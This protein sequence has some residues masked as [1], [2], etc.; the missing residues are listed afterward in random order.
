MSLFSSTGVRLNHR[1]RSPGPPRPR[2]I[3]HRGQRGRHFAAQGGAI[4]EPG[5]DLQATEPQKLEGADLQTPQIRSKGAF[6]QH[7]DAVRG[8]LAEPGRCAA[9]KVGADRDLGGGTGSMVQADQI[10]DCQS[11]PF[12]HVLRSLCGKRNRYLRRP[13]TVMVK[14][15]DRLGKPKPLDVKPRRHDVPKPSRFP[16]PIPPL[17]CGRTRTSC[18]RWPR[19][20]CAW[21]VG[22]R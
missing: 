10:D 16:S 7:S 3:A 17:G 12:L 4:T 14:F 19:C 2:L 21:P 9:P 15:P 1:V 5:F 6:N 20:R 8:D 22:A 13:S 18:C 11:T